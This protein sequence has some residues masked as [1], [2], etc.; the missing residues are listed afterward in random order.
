MYKVLDKKA[1]NNTVLNLNG[2]LMRMGLDKY[3]IAGYL[4]CVDCTIGETPRYCIRFKRNNQILDV[5]H[6]PEQLIDKINNYALVRKIDLTMD[7]LEKVNDML[8]N[9]TGGFIRIAKLAY[10]LPLSETGDIVGYSYNLCYKVNNEWYSVAD[11]FTFADIIIRL[12]QTLNLNQAGFI[13]EIPTKF[14]K[15]ND[16]RDVKYYKW[17]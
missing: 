7:N 6:K 14:R 17:K 5:R 8:D 13:R 10:T 12:Q 2:Y 3:L 4:V 1:V 15:L 11:K 9:K 16:I